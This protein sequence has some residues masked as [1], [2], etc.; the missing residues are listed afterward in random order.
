[1]TAALAAVLFL[2]DQLKE[3]L[4]SASE[5]AALL[6]E[7][8]DKISEA[9]MK[10]F[11]DAT[12]SAV[13]AMQALNEEQVKL[14]TAYVEGTAAM[15]ARL[16]QYDAERDAVIKVAEAKQ[17]T[18]EAEL[19]YEVELGGIGK[20]RADSDIAQSKLQ[21]DAQR[22]AADSAKLE[23]E[24]EERRQ[25]LDKASFR[26]RTGGDEERF[27]S[28]KAA[29]APLAGA[30]T[31]SEEA[32]KQAASGKFQST[33]TNWRGSSEGFNGTIEDLKTRIQKER[34]GQ[35]NAQQQNMPEI[36]DRYKHDAEALEEILKSQKKYVENLHTA[37]EID[38]QKLTAAKA[39]TEEYAEQLRHDQE[40]LRSGKDQIDVL[41]KQLELQKQ[42]TREVQEQHRAAADLNART[43]DH[44]E[45]TRAASGHGTA[46]EQRDYG[47]AQVREL[48]SRESGPGAAIDAGG[49]IDRARQIEMLTSGQGP[50]ALAPFMAELHGILD[51][52]LGL[53]QS[54][55]AELNSQRSLLAE[56]AQRISNMESSAAVNR[57]Y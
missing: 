1:M 33:F 8:T 19:H 32:E 35:D 10:G 7:Q 17:A 57:S 9:R 4:T 39:Q 22:G 36:A 41:Q 47:D 2:V 30:A 50:Q 3:R 13:E 55:A 11:S 21:L 56:Y 40:I 27:R 49:L 15:D 42:V 24:I 46:Q 29:E 26:L 53:Q 45:R 31:A 18:F 6:A 44:Q 54:H 25:E 28:S 20:E 51:G 16:K 5:A 14:N 23:M 37:A 52:I 12:N 48:Y 34:E 38:K 43:E